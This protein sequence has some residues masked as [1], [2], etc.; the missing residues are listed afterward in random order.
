MIEEM[1]DVVVVGAGISGLTAARELQRSGATRWAGT[2]HADQFAGYLEGAIRFGE[3]AAR[4]VLDDLTAAA[5]EQT[6]ESQR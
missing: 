6:K 3:H 5:T 2:E 4:A 1:A